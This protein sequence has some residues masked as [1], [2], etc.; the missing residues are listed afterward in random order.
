MIKSS[1]VSRAAIAA[2]LAPLAAAAFGGG[3][4]KSDNGPSPTFAQSMASSFCGALHSCCDTAKYA[5]D[6]SSCNAQLVNL[7][8]SFYEPV[9]HGNVI[10]DPSVQGACQQAF[11]D[12]ESKCQDKYDAGLIAT[13]AGNADPIAA[14]CFGLLKGTIQP[15]QPCTFDGECA[16]PNPETAGSCQ[17][18]GTPNAPNPNQTVCFTTTFGAPPGSQCNEGSPHYQTIGCDGSQGFCTTLIGAEGAGT[19]QGF[20]AN[21]AACSFG[22]PNP[23]V[24]NP[25]TSYCDFTT[26]KCTPIPGAGQACP[27]GQCTQ[28]AYCDQTVNP[29]TCAAQKPEGS[30]CQ[31]PNECTSGNCSFSADAGGQRCGPSFAPP[32]LS[33]YDVSPRTCGFGPM[34][35]APEEAGAVPPKTQSLGTPQRPRGAWYEQL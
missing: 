16:V 30:P 18:D 12:R 20:A 6:D 19:C 4:S 7:F 5:Y 28:G 35:T 9:N 27:Q 13:D 32:N 34:T 31:Q 23:Q 3:C 25:A 33:L 14:A 15:G 24:C 11:A 2:F 29:A 10:Y 8:Q 1:L 17:F 21:G 26:M 22:G